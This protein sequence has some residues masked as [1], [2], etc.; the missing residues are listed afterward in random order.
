[1]IN[2]KRIIITPGEPSGIGIDLVI[3]MAQLIWPVELVVCAD[4]N[5]LINRSLQLNLPIK[6]KLYQKNKSPIINKKGEITIFDVYTASTVKTGI[7]NYKNSNYVLKTLHYA[8]DGCLNG[9]FAALVTG[10][11]HKGIMNIANIKFTGHT[12]FFAKKS[13]NPKVIMMFIN[14][15]L[16]IALATTHIPIS[17]ISSIITKTLLTETINTLQIG[18]QKYFNIKKPIIYI[19]GLNPHAGEDGYIGKEELTVIKPTIFDL[20]LKG[21]NIIGP[22]PADSIFQQNILKHADVIL[23]MYHDQGLPVLKYIGFNNSIHITL[24]LPFIRTSVDHGVALN[25][26]GTGNIKSNSM[27]QAIKLAIKIIKQMYY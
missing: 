11:V 3:I 2:K 7:L 13:G 18:L 1:M 17:K 9:D 4:P 26:A 24:G 14:K 23:T 25:L 8:C 10:P 6:L 21:L 16:K 12:E 27:K 20:K 5:L 19:C 22:L 15:K